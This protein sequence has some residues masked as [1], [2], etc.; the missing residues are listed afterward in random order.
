MNY[1]G[2]E[3]GVIG[4]GDKGALRRSHRC[5]KLVIP[6]PATCNAAPMFSLW[7]LNVCRVLG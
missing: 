1:T 4:S 5:C 6:G 3:V 2:V 7:S